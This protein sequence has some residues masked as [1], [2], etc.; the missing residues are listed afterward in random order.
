MKYFLMFS[1]IG[2]M[3]VLLG[4]LK[5]PSSQITWMSRNY[6]MTLRGVSILTVIWA[7][8]GACY[9][10][11]GIQFIAGIG[12][13]LFII[14]SGY[15]LQLSVQTNGLND[16]WKRR[17]LHVMLPYWVVEGIGLLVSGRLK[18]RT[19]ILDCMFIKPAIGPGWFMQYIII[20]YL[21]FYLATFAVQKTTPKVPKQLKKQLLYG[22]FL[23]WF[24]IDSLLFANPEMPFL[25][26]RQMLCFPFGVAIA[27]NKERFE[28]TAD[29]PKSFFLGS[30][31]G[32]LF[33]GIT[34]FSVVKELPYLF[35][36]VLSLLTV[37]PL[38]I[39]VL[40]L[41]KRHSWILNNWVF[42]Q[43]GLVSFEIYLIHAFAMEILQPSLASFVSFLSV[44]I[45]GVWLLHMVR[46]KGKEIWAI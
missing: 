45:L 4:Y 29:R 33:M 32:L 44:T 37:F 24:V 46:R 42:K 14:L 39:A 19:Y 5:H 18:L 20:C 10:I 1:G 40:S 9:G 31:I 35:Q 11:R 25:K 36:N 8:V 16:Y 22:A 17:I 27:G 41:T 38:A 15:G 2:L 21:L 28:V 13:S 23:I 30:G 3:V 26:A 34:Q 6:T 12:V 7:H 43:V